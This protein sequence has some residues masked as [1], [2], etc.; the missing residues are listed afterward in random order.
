MSKVEKKGYVDPGWPQHFEGEGHV[1]TELIGHYA[2]AFSPFGDEL[3]LPIPQEDL[4]YVHP[5]TRINK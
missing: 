3:S 4:G 5:Y 2:G 1:V